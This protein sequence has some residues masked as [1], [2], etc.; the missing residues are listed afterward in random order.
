M[1]GRTV[2]TLE[3]LYRDHL[4]H[5]N[6]LRF[7]ARGQ[8]MLPMIRSGDTV[9]V[10]PLDRLRKG[11][12]LL[13]ERDGRWFVHRLICDRG[14]DVSRGR[15]V[16]RGDGL[17]V[18]DPPVTAASVLGRV[19]GIER[20]SRIVWLDG[21]IGTIYR[22]AACIPGLRYPVIPTVVVNVARAKRLGCRWLGLRQA[23]RS[24][25]S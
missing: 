24:I 6:I 19:T 12:V 22:W 23:P 4:A 15:L 25:I 13:Y 16:L 20:R 3:S 10:A 7:R 8:S 14:A 18:A 9:R 5:R 21:P 17:P 2:L 1:R 11:D